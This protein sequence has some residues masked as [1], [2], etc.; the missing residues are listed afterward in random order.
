[1]VSVI[2]TVYNLER[3]LQMCV[4]SILDSTYQDFQLILVDDGSTD[5]SAAICDRYAAADERILVFHK[6][7]G[8]AYE[9]RNTGL[10]NAAGDYIMF[11]DGDDVIHPNMI[12]ILADAIQEGDYDFS[13]VKGLP[14]PENGYVE[15]LKDKELGLAASRK[16]LTQSDM[17]KGLFGPS[18][19]DFQ[20]IVVWNKLFKRDLVKDLHFV[21][22]GS[23]DA[24]WTT[25]MCMRMNQA[26]MV[27]ENLY[28]WIQHQASITHKGMNPIQV[29]RINSY[30]LCL[31]DIPEDKTQYRTWCLE[32]LYKVV[33]H[34]RYNARN[35]K[36]F[37]QVKSLGKSAYKQTIAEFLRS[38]STWLTKSALLFFYHIPVAYYRYMDRKTARA[39]QF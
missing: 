12:K 7:N 27:E 8:G 2:I 15:K 32:K 10:D 9:A 39:R 34:T 21:N 30:L 36:Y 26:M 37:N 18:G 29:D 11:V 6:E 31:K 19:F 33:L 17:V 5:G 22:T 4:E 28:Y 35:S 24:E 25:R 20:Y 38:G 14:V 13:M 1:M 3:Y 23:E 16:T